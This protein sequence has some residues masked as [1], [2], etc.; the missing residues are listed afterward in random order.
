MRY[1]ENNVIVA[2]VMKRLRHIHKKISVGELQ[3]KVNLDGPGMNGH[4][5]G[6]HVWAV[7]NDVAS[8]IT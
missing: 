6:Q 2:C 8:I 4:I 1:T 3:L 5:L 7:I